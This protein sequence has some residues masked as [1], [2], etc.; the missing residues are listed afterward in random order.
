MTSAVN[1]R[2]NKYCFGLE[3]F[4]VDGRMVTKADAISGWLHRGWNW[5]QCVR[6][7]ENYVHL[8][9]YGIEGQVNTQ[10]EAFTRKQ[11]KGCSPARR[12]SISLVT[13]RSESANGHPG[14]RRRDWKP[15]WNG[16]QRHER[17]M[18]FDPWPRLV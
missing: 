3:L 11:R 7:F 13:M 14:P 2:W 4:N 5:C 8:A 12:A 15:L 17:Q 9:L 16:I 1:E 10:E 18:I 6:H